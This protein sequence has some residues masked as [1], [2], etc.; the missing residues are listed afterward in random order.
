MKIILLGAPGSG[1]GTLAK[2]I[3]KYREE[4]GKFTSREQIKN[5]NKL[6][7]KTYELSVGF[8]RILSGQEIFDET[9]IHP[10]NYHDASVLLNI[11]T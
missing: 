6:G 8:L 1:K 10:D 11:F 3:V 7:N 4:H 5:V 2:N 9:S